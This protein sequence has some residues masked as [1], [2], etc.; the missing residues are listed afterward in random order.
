MSFSAAKVRSCSSSA[1]GGPRAPNGESATEL[2]GVGG[3]FAVRGGVAGGERGPLRAGAG[4]RGAGLPGRG[5]GRA[6][7]GMHGRGGIAPRPSAPLPGPP[8]THC[9]PGAAA[10]LAAPAAQPWGRLRSRAGEARPIPPGCDAPL[11]RGI[12]AGPGPQVFSGSA[13]PGAGAAVA[14]RE[15]RLLRGSLRSGS[16]RTSAADAR[17]RLKGAA[18]SGK[19]AGLGRPRGGALGACSRGRGRGART[20]SETCSPGGPALGPCP[21]LR[22]RRVQVQPNFETKQYFFFFGKYDLTEP[23]SLPSSP[24]PPPPKVN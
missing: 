13:P 6:G 16:R 14:P 24:R 9:L 12:P 20:G 3:S 23:L 11:P 17:E 18:A 19:H 5:R 21:G 7:A 22:F 2:G 10:R 4:C 15:L 8:I 1:R